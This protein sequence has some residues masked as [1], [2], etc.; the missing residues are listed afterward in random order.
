LKL[1]ALFFATHPDDA[2][3][4]CG[5][6][7]IKLV[8]N[9]RKVGIVDLTQGELASRGTV[10]SRKH[11]TN[12]A[13]R[14]LGISMRKNLKIKDGNIENNEQNRLKIIKIIREFR[15]EIV[16]LPYGRDR[17]PDHV[18]AHNLIKDAIFYSGLIKLKSSVSGKQQK[19]F[20]PSRTY[21]Y[22][23][24]YPFDPTFIIDISVEFRKKMEVI[25]CYSTQFYNPKFKSVE[26]FISSKNFMEYIEARARYYGFM[27]NS[28]FGEA[29][30]SENAIKLN[31]EN[32]FI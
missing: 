12:A 24:T 20:R 28:E 32:L 4:C 27:I 26:T 31:P 25:K 30:Y 7:M 1:D 21:F 15:P 13:T 14:L 11:E 6:L 10:T 23:Q 17:H 19:H 3:L 5:G 8:N 29:Y 18:N 16:F 22:M 2:E 9:G